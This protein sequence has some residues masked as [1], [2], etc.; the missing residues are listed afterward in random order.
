LLTCPTN[1]CLPIFWIDRHIAL[2]TKFP[3]WRAKPFSQTSRAGSA[4]PVALRQIGTTGK[5]P[6][7]A[8]PKSA[9]ISSHPVPTRGAVARRH[10]RGMGCGGRESVGAQLM[11]QGGLNLVS[12][13]QARRTNDV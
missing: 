7:H 2:P 10:E 6:L 11:S 4:L 9:V 13:M 3:A 1:D 12:D 8:D 5:L